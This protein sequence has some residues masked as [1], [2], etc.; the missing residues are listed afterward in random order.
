MATIRFSIPDE[1]ERE[2]RE[3][4]AGENEHVIIADLIRQAVARRR[5]QGRRAA[6]VEALLVMRARLPPTT[7]GEVARTRRADRP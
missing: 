1:V 3:T 7:A 5:R 4:F 6:A 2:F